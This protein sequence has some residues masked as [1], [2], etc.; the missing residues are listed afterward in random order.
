MAQK[1]ISGKK[2]R[3]INALKHKTLRGGINIQI[4]RVC[5][6]NKVQI[7]LRIILFILL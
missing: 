1:F 5:L 6:L 2:K 4:L 3:V 7:K